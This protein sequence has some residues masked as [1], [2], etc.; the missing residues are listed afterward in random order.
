VLRQGGLALLERGG[1]L[2]LRGR[3]GLVWEGQQ[4]RGQGG[5]GLL[6]WG[7]VLWGLGPGLQGRG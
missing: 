7:H 6:G 4:L 3:G 1:G 2:R 5:Q